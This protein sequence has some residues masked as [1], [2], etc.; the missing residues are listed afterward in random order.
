MIL[1]APSK[2]FLAGEYA[3][4]AGAQALILNTTPRF[5]L[6]VEEGNGEVSGIPDGSP[7]Y[8]WL[9]QRSPLVQNLKIT[10][11][12]PHLGRGGFGASGAQ[13]LLAHALTGV[14]QGARD[15]DAADLIHDYHI[16]A[17]NSGGSGADVL[18]QLRGGLAIVDA[19]KPSVE[20][21][22]WPFPELAFAIVRTGRK[23]A[24][25]EHLRMIQAEDLLPLVPLAQEVVRAVS[26][27]SEVFVAKV[28][29]YGRALRELNL[30]SLETIQIL[31]V[32]ERQDWCLAAKGCGAF[33]ADTFLLLF[34]KNNFAE[35]LAFTER[36]GFQFAA[37]SLSGGLEVKREAH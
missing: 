30:Q 24:T 33:G 19:R 7:A 9:R 26:K 31:N 17:K 22:A 14:L 23:V 34:H 13:F 11:K 35:A 27:N 25:H 12:D 20:S 28:R 37:T 16:C 18:S 4:L 5:E 21:R 10:F 8:V 32:F 29:N 1:T 3:V 36:E 6:K 15:E 2:T